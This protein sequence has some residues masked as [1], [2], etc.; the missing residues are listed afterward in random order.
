MKQ[1]NTCTLFFPSVTP[2]VNL[3]RVAWRPRDLRQLKPRNEFLPDE[4]HQPNPNPK[5]PSRNGNMHAAI[6]SFLAGTASEEVTDAEE[7]M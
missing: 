7:G 5:K 3:L 1:K 6:A 4:R 2:K